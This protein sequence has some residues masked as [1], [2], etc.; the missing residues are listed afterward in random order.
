MNEEKNVKM[1]LGTLE[2]MD[3]HNALVDGLTGLVKSKEAQK[4]TKKYIKKGR[5]YFIDML[6]K[7]LGELSN[8]GEV[9]YDAMGKVLKAFF[10]SV[11]V[12]L[13]DV[14]HGLETVFTVED[15]WVNLGYGSASEMRTRSYWESLH[16]IFPK[17]ADDEDLIRRVEDKRGYELYRKSIKTR[18][19]TEYMITNLYEIFGEDRVKEIGT[20]VRITDAMAV[21]NVT[22]PEEA[23]A[24]TEQ[25]YFLRTVECIRLIAATMCNDIETLMVDN[26]HAVFALEEYATKGYS[27]LT[28]KFK[29]FMFDVHAGI[30]KSLEWLKSLKKAESVE[31]VD[32][33]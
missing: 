6:D 18:K 23:K 30:R 31:D 1:N 19:A 32:Q 10:E 2:I 27:I 28:V 29:V 25:R 3:F 11:E 4:L 15:I 5:K 24:I 22:D 12:V 20:D 8:T 21:A 33:D 13:Q 26:T 16:G 17:D 14:D 9:D 7:T